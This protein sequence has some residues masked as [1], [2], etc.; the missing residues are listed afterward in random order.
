MRDES[1]S[2]DVYE[3]WVAKRGRLRRPLLRRFWPVTACNDTNPHLVFRPREKEKYKLRK[4]RQNDLE[5]LQKLRRLKRDFSRLK[6]M[7]ALALR[8]ELL[9]AH[10]ADLRTDVF[11]QAS[12]DCVDTSGLPRQSTL[13]DL[14]AAER[15]L[16][17]PLLQ[18]GE[19]AP[20][21]ESGGKKKRKRQKDGK[22]GEKTVKTLSEEEKGAEDIQ[23]AAD[24]PLPGPVPLFTDRLQTREVYMTN[25]SSHVPHVPTYVATKKKRQKMIVEEEKQKEEKDE[26]EETGMEKDVL[27]HHPLP[28]NKRHYRYRYRGRIGRGG[29]L[30][31]DR[32]PFRVPTGGKGVPVIHYL[33][34][35]DHAPAAVA[36]IEAKAIGVTSNLLVPTITS[37]ALRTKIAEIGAAWSDDD[38]EELVGTGE[39][40]AAEEKARW[41]D[42]RLRI[43]L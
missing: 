14:A 11:E 13:T 9:L 10:A 8:R 25:W 26:K 31:I 2:A 23:Q 27:L 24:A 28:S 38:E 5:A 4:K 19:N 42:E 37:S 41:G 20:V 39:W 1:I 16:A 30:C 22:V 3:Y 18:G 33:T 7:C 21:S 35:L 40:A 29:R 6:T 34:K 12:H 43:H 32:I 36:P 15:L 17:Q